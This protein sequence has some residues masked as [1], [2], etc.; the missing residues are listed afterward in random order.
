MGNQQHSMVINVCIT[1]IE[2]LQVMRK[3][4]K[5]HS[6]KCAMFIK[7]F[8]PIFHT[9]HKEKQF[10]LKCVSHK[11]K[12]EIYKQKIAPNPSLSWYILSLSLSLFHVCMVQN[13]VYK[14]LFR[15]RSLL[16]TSFCIHNRYYCMRW[17]LAN[18]LTT[19]S[20]C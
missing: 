9:H 20:G 3:G 4:N 7:C 14:V 19:I 15:S 11:A 1:F 8:D 10:R 13:H 5:D 6:K 12:I 17:I 2:T 16:I 18:I